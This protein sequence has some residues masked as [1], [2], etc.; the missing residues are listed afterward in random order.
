M[1]PQGVEVGLVVGGGGDD[2]L[3]EQRVRARA[4]VLGRHAEHGRVGRRLA[5]DLGGE[6]SPIADEGD[7]VAIPAP[8]PLRW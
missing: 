8:Q 6:R 5:G 2:V 3:A 1:P 7:E 4:V